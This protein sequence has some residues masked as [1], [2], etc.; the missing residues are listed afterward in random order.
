M[1]VRYAYILV[2]RL[3][4]ALFGVLLGTLCMQ[5]GADY[6]RASAQQLGAALDVQSNKTRM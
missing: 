2:A 3:P 1:D 6:D 4:R 5:K